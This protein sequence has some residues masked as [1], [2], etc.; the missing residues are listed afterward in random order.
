MRSVEDG[1]PQG[2]STRYSGEQWLS[3][4]S[5][6]RVPSSARAMR[7]QS[8]AYNSARQSRLSVGIKKSLTSDVVAH[9]VQGQMN[10]RQCSRHPNHAHNLLPQC[11]A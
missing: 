3:W 6:L 10:V 7:Y 11:E 8:W 4:P 5:G 1:V 9:V 2:R